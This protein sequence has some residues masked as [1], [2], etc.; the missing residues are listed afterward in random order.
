MT[1]WF[2]R[3]RTRLAGVTV[4]VAASLILPLLLSGCAVKS[5][6]AE[7]AEAELIQAPALATAQPAP[8]HLAV[9]GELAGL[10]AS[11]PTAYPQAGRIQ[12]TS[13]QGGLDLI[14]SGYASAA[15]LWGPAPRVAAP[16]AAEAVAADALAVVVH[17]LN[18]VGP[19]EIAQLADIF[20]GRVQEWG[21]FG[22]SQGRILVVARE[23]GSGPRQALADLV[24]LGAPLSGGALI[25]GSSSA[26]LDSVAANPSAIG[27]VPASEL[28]GGVRVLTVEGARPEP[29][30]VRVG[31]YSL[32]VGLWLVY[33]QG[34]A[35]EQL[36]D[37]LLSAG[38]QELL[39]GRYAP[40]EVLAKP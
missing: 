33:R 3:D 37:F 29:A 38:G 25:A 15:L 4:V 9:A 21:S 28:R 13:W 27:I 19:L 26:V 6:P 8:L 2:G 34:Q 30:N 36:G 5:F 12:Y 16:L 23:P 32:M 24:L 31:K 40:S 14:A 35:G 20:S 10:A 18:R 7:A 39:A 11:L 17:P 1:D 22:Q